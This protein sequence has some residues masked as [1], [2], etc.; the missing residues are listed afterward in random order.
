MVKSLDIPVDGEKP[1]KK[2]GA[3]KEESSESS[4]DEESEDEVPVKNV[5][6]KEESSDDE[7]S[8]DE[9]DE[10]PVSKK[11]KAESNDED[12]EDESAVKKAKVSKVKSVPKKVN[13]LVQ[14]RFQR[15]KAEKVEF[16]DDRL[17]DNRFE[18][19]GGAISS[20]GLKAHEDLIVTRGKG[21]AKE[22]N[23]KKRGSYR[24]GAIDQQS[25]SI[26]FNYNGDMRIL[27][28]GGVWKNTEDEILKAAVMKYGKNQ[29]ARISSLLTRKTPK[30]CKARWFEWLDPSIKKTEWAKD[31]D[32]K[33]LH[34]AKLMPT[35]WRTIAPIVGRTPSQCLERYQFLLE[36]AEAKEDDDAGP[37][38]DDVRRLRPGEIDPEPESKP[39]RP[40][41]VDMD[42]D[43]KE[44]LSEA[45]A[46]LANTQGKK[47]KRKAREKQLEEARRL[48]SLQK[49]RELK[50]AGIETNMKPKKKRG[51]D[52][53]ADIPF[54]KRA[55]VGFFDVGEEK[56]REQ[57]EKEKGIGALLSQLDGK[58]RSEVEEDERKK[59]AKKQ[60]IAKEKGDFVPPKAL[61]D[62]AE[63]AANYQTSARRSLVLP[64]PQVGDAEI[65]EL[66]KIKARE[67]EAKSVIDYDDNSSATN[68]LLTEYKPSVM[69]PPTGGFGRTPLRTPATPVTDSLKVQARNLR[70]ISQM[71][72]PLLGE[73]VELE[74]ED[75]YT[76]QTGSTP[77]SVQ[78]PNPLTAQLT[79]RAGV[80]G[81]A[82]PRS[83]FGGSSRGGM[84][85]RDEMGINTPLR[86]DG[87]FDETPRQKQSVVRQQLASLFKSLPAPTNDFKVVIP[88]VKNVDDEDVNSIQDEGERRAAAK[89]EDME[90]VQAR[91]FKNASQQE[92]TRLL[93]RSTA[94]QRNLP[95]PLVYYPEA[96]EPEV[97]KKEKGH[98]GSPLSKSDDPTD[99]IRQEVERMLL[100]DM[101]YNPIPHQ[102]RVPKSLAPPLS[103][104]LQ[105]TLD[106]L[107][108]ANDLI[109]EE[110]RS[111]RTDME[112]NLQEL[113][114]RA[115]SEYMF[116]EPTTSGDSAT[117]RFEKISS[118]TPQD[119]LANYTRQL[120]LARETMKRDHTKAQKLEK[121]LTVTCGGYV[122]RNSKLKRDLA[123]TVKELE[124]DA[125]KLNS[126]RV[127]K[128]LEDVAILD[129]V[130]GL[131]S[132][133]AK[134]EARETLLQERYQSLAETREQLLESLKSGAGVGGMV[135]GDPSR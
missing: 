57:K 58:R 108:R 46:R 2:A 56:G 10:K 11:R 52:Y 123:E 110:L 42:E 12:D 66:V 24:G 30:Q 134:L 21:F 104:D 17:K 72:T 120:E 13:I 99:L 5:A 128:G 77:R 50:A 106:E 82:T 118:T 116:F 94:V 74:G 102:T 9:E 62:A 31:E 121:K 59:D 85:P 87:G 63:D 86:S 8:G 126:F 3:A 78:T 38:A 32:E 113:H 122:A 15:V 6:K 73:T 4:S 26:K 91:A 93:L 112:T 125:V 45:R 18:A 60:K 23:K 55:P 1:A 100:H 53:N 70:A 89:V 81:G 114:E 37:N 39:A 133:V 49:R 41:P 43:E 76:Y 54:Q 101:A 61:R 20:Y 14:E 80:A 35:Q 129:R 25:Y 135:S 84:T 111:C 98:A 40:D 29:W 64:A 7:S 75:A 130:E 48:A 103:A 88:K 34:L 65:E 107:S 92:Q 79:P 19:K 105:V 44:M 47:A 28:K 16:A 22:K 67:D 127:M 132:E 97:Q 71:Q 115:A 131:K 83:E 69:G 119:R 96:F 36:E 117:G 124:D 27:I 33:L 51:M 90:D 95:R 68:A 109:L